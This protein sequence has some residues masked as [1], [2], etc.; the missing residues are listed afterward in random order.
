M[1]TANTPGRK[2]QQRE[3]QF[4]DVGVQGRK[5]G[6]TLP[7]GR[8]DEHDIEEL[9]GIFSSPE[10]SPVKAPAPTRNGNATLMS[11]DM[12]VAKSSGLEPTEVLSH[13]RLVRTSKTVL[14]PPPGRSPHK[15]NIGSSPRRQ[16]SVAPMSSVRRLTR[17]PERATS[18]PAVAR[19]LFPSEEPQPS[20]EKS[21]RASR[22]QTRRSIYDLEPSEERDI[23]TVPEEDY[24]ETEAP[25]LLHGAEP[26]VNGAFHSDPLPVDDSLQVLNYSIANE[27][28]PQDDFPQTSSPSNRRIRTRI[29]KAAAREPEPE[30]EAPA[31][32]RRGRPPGRK[33]PPSPEDVV[34]QKAPAQQRRKPKTQGLV[35]ARARHEEPEP[36]PVPEDSMIDDTISS[37]PQTEAPKRGRGRPKSKPT[38]EPEPEPEPEIEPNEE[39]IELPTFDEAPEEAPEEEE[40]AEA[41]VD[42]SIVEIA[43]KRGRGRPRKSLPTE[44]TTA[45]APA[46]R[47]R[48]R[49]KK[50]STTDAP[51]AK[52]KGKRPARDDEDD[53]APPSPKRA[54]K[55]VF[56]AFAPPPRAA[57]PLKLGHSR[58]I[59]VLR[60]VQPE[61]EAATTTRS[62]RHSVK[63]IAFWTGEKIEYDH[64]RNIQRVVRADSVELP[65]TKRGPKKKR[66][67]ALERV[68]EEEEEEEEELAEWE[69]GPGVFRGWCARWGGEG[70]EVEDDYEEQIAFAAQ[71]IRT[72]EVAGADFRYAKVLSLPFFGAG[73]LDIPPGGSK[74]MKNSRRMQYVFFV[75][76][77]RLD[78]AIGENE[79]VIGRGGVWHV[80]RGNWY[81][82]SNNGTTAARVFFAQG[83]EVEGE[84]E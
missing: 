32:K 29:E 7:E 36:E 77:G 14:P 6:I 70:V 25:D 43:P 79:F 64:E 27:E 35:S 62:G 68:K 21:P 18:H 66:K 65:K 49:P 26:A 28:L 50:V 17:S 55:D 51:T 71:A 52:A 34:A 3:N 59:S 10:K 12:E 57:S 38:P 41:G 40:Q 47:G 33:L 84:E 46:K 72:N 5:T 24:D 42:S 44:G 9:D 39:Q 48:G 4:F 13:R 16:S 37:L 78:V 76:A 22:P 54:R 15:T 20:V 53:E 2:K 69:S 83:C 74:R 82:I 60:D 30:P 1:A 58:S 81:S 23:G 67:G 73:M 63:P 11:S 75:H 45:E 31:P 56:A 8:R 61:E 80:P 19:R